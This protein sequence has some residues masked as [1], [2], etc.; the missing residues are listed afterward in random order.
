MYY[1]IFICF[2]DEIKMIQTSSSLVSRLQGF[3]I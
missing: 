1:F 3:E 2:I